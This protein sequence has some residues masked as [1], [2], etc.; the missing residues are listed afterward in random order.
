MKVGDL[1]KRTPEWGEWVKNNPWM[2]VARDFE[3]G[4]II[5]CDHHNRQRLVSWTGRLKWENNKDLIKVITS[6]EGE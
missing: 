2:H 6:L 4:I 3:I 1:V 5:Q